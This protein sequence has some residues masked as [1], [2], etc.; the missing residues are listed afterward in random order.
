MQ[1]TDHFSLEELIASEIAARKGIDNTPSNE[2]IENLEV[3]AAGLER[4][5]AVLGQP[6][7]VNSGYRCLALNTAIGG[8]PDSMHIQGLAADIVCPRF[9]APLQVCRAIRDAG[10]DTDQII[11]EFGA[12]THV[13][14]PAPGKDARH[15]LLTTAS[16]GG[17]VDGLNPI[18]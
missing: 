8:A 7:H 3:L 16:G 14:F 5:R 12:W 6:I 10:L 18:A 1:L 9:G 13:A 15:R 2:I 17:Y 4:V 11:H